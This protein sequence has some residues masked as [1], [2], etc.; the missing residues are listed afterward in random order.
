MTSNPLRT[1]HRTGNVLLLSLLFGAVVANGQ[2]QDDRLRQEIRETYNFSPREL[3]GAAIDAKSAVLDAFWTKAKAQKDLYLP[4]LRTELVRVDVPP[5]FFY[6]GSMLLLAL[7][8]T[9]ADRRLALDAVSRCDLR[10]VQH[11]D[12]FRQVHRLATLGED[13]T[14]AALHILAE[15]DF[16][17]FVPQH[18]LTL[19][20]DYSLVYLLLPVD[21]ARWL[22][23]AL[24]RLSTESESTAQKSLL[25]LAWY[26]QTKEADAAV[27]AF[28]TAP[29]KPAANRAFARDLLA[30]NAGVS[31]SAS[32]TLEDMLRA[33]RRDIMKNVSDEA[34]IELDRKTEQIMASRQ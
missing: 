15:P 20:Q 24:A 29:A 32:T 4:V 17:V 6:D 21:P 13:T 3:T 23:Q 7:S 19:A 1:R 9:P 14:S 31:R 12:Y 33:E 34:L 16:R 22:P 10:D 11:A 27:S 5:F 30:R 26:A 25:L 18:S 8:D 28:S 2:A